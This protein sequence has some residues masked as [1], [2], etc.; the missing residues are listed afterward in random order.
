MAE[1]KITFL[2]HFRYAFKIS[3]DIILLFIGYSYF[4]YKNGPDTD[5]S[6]LRFF[7]MAFLLE[8]V[9]TVS[10]HLNYY[11]FN[12]KTRIESVFDSLI[13]NNL[14]HTI[15][16]GKEDISEIVHYMSFPSRNKKIPFLPW[17]QYSHCIIKLKNGEQVIL[18]SLLIYDL[19]P[20]MKKF[21]DGIPIT[22]EAGFYRWISKPVLD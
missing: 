3:I 21:A 15:R 19:I 14:S 5:Y 16:F 20:F 22:I 10:L 2:S 8:F 18:T 4:L 7:I 17:D 13:V 11:S 1:Y 6:T 12:K 9:P